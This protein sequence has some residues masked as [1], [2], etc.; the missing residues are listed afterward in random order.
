MPTLKRGSAFF[1]LSF[2]LV[3]GRQCQHGLQLVLLQNWYCIVVPPV[4]KEML[5][6]D[7]YLNLWFSLGHFILAE[8][9]SMCL[10]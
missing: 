5:N 1:F 3:A 4:E 6:F 2:L 7:S 9:P 10:A 8:F